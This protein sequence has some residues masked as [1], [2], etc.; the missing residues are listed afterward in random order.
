MSA[1]RYLV[2]RWFASLVYFLL[3]NKFR[4]DAAIFCVVT[5]S[6]GKTIVRRTI[7]QSLPRTTFTLHTDYVNEFGVILSALGIKRFSVLSIR[8]WCDLW[9]S[10]PVNDRLILVE[11]G[12]DFRLDIQWFTKRFK[13]SVLILT[14]GTDTP[15]TPYIE[16][17]FSQRMELANSVVGAGGDVYVASDDRVHLA[18]LNGNVVTHKV[19]VVTD[20]VY[21]YARLLTQHIAKR[22]GEECETPSTF[23]NQRLQTQVHDGVFFYCDTY[24]VTPVCFEVFLDR[25]NADPGK[26]K[27]LIMSE[28]RPTKASLSVLY[29]PYI[30]RLDRLTSILFVGDKKI[31]RYLAK[32]LDNI[33]YVADLNEITNDDIRYSVV[34]IKTA[35]RYRGDDFYKRMFGSR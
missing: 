22:L 26:D 21:S 16:K 14:K 13:T 17:V 34:G 23:T 20:D 6:V 33:S 7:G 32:K 30:G 29:D 8:S 28:I 3:L 25:I 15:W 24:K 12:A 27:I 5:G 10:R 9:S 1:V 4:G 35:A 18:L 2:I 31:F 19:V 11:M